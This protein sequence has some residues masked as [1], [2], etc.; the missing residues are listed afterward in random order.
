MSGGINWMFNVPLD[1][2][3]LDAMPS[4]DHL[5]AGSARVL[6]FVLDRA[7]HLIPMAP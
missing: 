7:H 2:P 5:A 3:D 4:I 6:S 1:W